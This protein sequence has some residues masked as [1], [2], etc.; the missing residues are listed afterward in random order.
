MSLSNEVSELQAE[1]FANKTKQE[2]LL[3]FTS[4]L[5]EK[6]IEMKSENQALDDKLQKLNR[7]HKQLLDEFEELNSQLASDREVCSPLL[8]RFSGLEVSRLRV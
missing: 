7:E 6:N 8:L 3:L 5:T 4:R 1:L 2:E